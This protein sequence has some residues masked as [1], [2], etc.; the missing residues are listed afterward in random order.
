VRAERNRRR[1]PPRPK[2][3]RWMRRIGGLVGTAALLGSGV[4]AA[5]MVLGDR[6][7]TAVVAPAP[8]ATPATSKHVATKA[9]HRSPPKP[10][11]LNKAQRAARSAAVRL[12]RSQG[13]TTLKPTDYD[14]RARLRV[15]IGRPLGDPAGGA[16]AFFF[17]GTTYLGHDAVGP[18]SM[19]RVRK[20][21]KTAV[22]L[23]YGVYAVG[24]R[25]GVPSGRKKVSF[26]LD[27]PALR[28]LDPIPVAAVRFQRRYG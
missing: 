28:P 25:P 13:Y 11:G 26:R 2:A 24:D 20:R 7:G 16:Y 27:G 14:P 19:L 8:A 22:M 21:A 5:M 9:K 18:S 4:A 10:K 1:L 17:A 3:Y 15:L 23:V 12:L 6:E